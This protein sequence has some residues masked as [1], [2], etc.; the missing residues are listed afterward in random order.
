M[1]TF[2]RLPIVVFLKNIP[3]LLV[4]VHLNEVW[5]CVISII[6]VPRFSRVSH[7]NPEENLRWVLDGSAFSISFKAETIRCLKLFHSCFSLQIVTLNGRQIQRWILRPVAYH[8]KGKVKLDS[9]Y[10]HI[11]GATSERHFFVS[12]Y[13]C[14]WR[15][16]FMCLTPGTAVWR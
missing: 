1:L 2:Y 12:P 13:N 8:L 5:Y 9:V 6:Y 3:L 14:C 7:R 16:V 11:F 4:Q 15:S 10:L